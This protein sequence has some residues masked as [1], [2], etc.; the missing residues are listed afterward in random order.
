MAIAA[1]IL[2]AG[3]SRRLGEPKQLIVFEGETLLNRAVRLARE[4][5]A[6][7]VLVVLG[8]YFAEICAALPSREVV[9]VHN[10]KWQTG[11]ASSVHAGM[12]AL[13]VCAPKAEGVLLLTCDQPRLTA[14]HLRNLIAACAE[15]KER[16]AASRYAGARG[17]P[18]AF[19]REVFPA[20][21]E[22]TGDKGARAIL[23]N[24]PCD[25]VEV[26][27]PG[28]EIDIDLPADLAALY[29]PH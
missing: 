2:A 6:D 26:D 9:L 17:T 7:P 14:E 27:F 3:A 11:M 5:G 15:K 20:L 12:C 28:G 16:I 29:R 10:D 21:S 18:A 23:T 1:M 4:V 22:L 25:L 24:P 8:A 13:G 19:P